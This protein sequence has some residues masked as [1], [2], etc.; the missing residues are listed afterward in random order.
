MAWFVT[1]REGS[2][3]TFTFEDGFE[4]ETLLRLVGGPEITDVSKLPT[5]ARAKDTRKFTTDI[6]SVGAGYAGGGGGAVVSQNLKDAIEAVEPGVHQFFPVVLKQQD[7]TPFD[8][9]FYLLRVR[10]RFP[11]VLFLESDHQPIGSVMVQPNFGQPIYNCHDTDL[12]ISKPA[13]AGHHLFSTSIVAGGKAIMSDALM[14]ECKRRKISGFRA[15][16]AK[17]LDRPW[18]AE[19]EVPELMRWLREH[20]DQAPQF[21][22]FFVG[23]RA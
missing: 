17:E 22:R 7:G 8:R 12:A 19:T 2:H 10:R 11:C 5:S 23:I 16:P 13:M 15:H 4:A 3:P 9:T 21:E 14:A 1:V 18:D 6:V 20:P